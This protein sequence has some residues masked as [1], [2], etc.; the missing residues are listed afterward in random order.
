M[1]SLILLDYD[2]LRVV[3]WLLLGV[4]LVAFAVMD[5]ADLGVASV[6][7][8]VAKTDD[9]RR[10][11]YN[12]IG[13][14]WE[15]NQVWLILAGGVV[16]AAW[17]L[18]YAMAFSGFYLAMMLLL[19]ALIVRPVAIKYR[20]KMASRRWRRN[21][22]AIWCATG[23]VATLV[24][25]VAIGN[26]ILGAP[27]TFDAATLRPMYQGSFIALFHPFALLCGVLSV[28]MLAFQGAVVLAWKTSDQVARR[29]RV[30]SAVLALVSIVLFAI[31]GFWVGALDG[32]QMAWPEVAGRLSNPLN[33]TVQVVQGG[34]LHNFEQWPLL[35]LAP[36]LGF[37]GFAMGALLA[38][39]G[40]GLL[41]LVFASFA[42]GGV[43]FTFGF[44]VFP[45]LLPSSSNPAASL[46]LFDAS[47]SHLTLWLMLILSLVFLPIIVLYTSWVFHV[48]RGKVTLKSVSEAGHSY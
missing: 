36:V 38:G 44:A 1:D 23:V 19:V 10:V 4:L 39:R 17:P 9:E 5:G 34:W 24:F 26:V 15:G 18:L 45:F 32:Y 7:P 37:V 47:A 12:V 25:G 29:S 48:M 33:K 3:W 20:G 2:T 27:F 35:W 16:F 46:S 31:G 41:G 40:R 28:T 21:W 6:L 30:W 14:V 22:D 42:I 13:P 43:I 11:L 8:L